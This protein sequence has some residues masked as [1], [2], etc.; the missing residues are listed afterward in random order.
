MKT[1]KQHRFFVPTNLTLHPRLKE[2]A[3][4]RSRELGYPS[5]SAYVADLLRE[6][7]EKA[8]IA[9]AIAAAASNPPAQ[10]LKGRKGPTQ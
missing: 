10:A 6:E 3:C 5:L 9:A 7:L 2:D 8:K 4:A 1:P